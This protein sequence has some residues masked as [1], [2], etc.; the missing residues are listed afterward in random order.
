MMLQHLLRRAEIGTLFS[1][2]V[3]LAF[4]T[5]L[6]LDLRSLLKTEFG[7]DA[8]PEDPQTICSMKF[9]TLFL[10]PSCAAGS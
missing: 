9:Q 1:W 4:T 2:L 7:L 8:H 10:P 3:D 6:L 5:Q